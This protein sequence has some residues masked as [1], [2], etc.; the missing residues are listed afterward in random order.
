MDNPHEDITYAGVRDIWEGQEPFGFRPA[1]RRQHIYCV[2]KTGTGKST[3]LRNLILQDLYSGFG[4]GV[5]DPHGDLT[6]DVLDQFPTWRTDDLVHFD[7]G[8]RE[9]PLALNLLSSGRGIS[10]HLI[11]SAVVSAF[12]AIWSE[13][14]GA[15]LEY[16]LFACVSALC[17]CQSVSLLG[18]GRM[19]SDIT[20]RNWVV[21][22]VKDPLVKSFWEREFAGYDK[23]FL[24]EVISPVQNKVG[25]LMMSPPLRN[26]L[27][28]VTSKVD[29]RFMLDR[30]RVFIASLSKGKLGEDKANLL[31][32]LIMSQFHLAAMSRADLSEIHRKPFHLYVDEFSSFATDTLASM[33][34][35]ARKYGLALVLGHQHTAQLKPH[36]REAVLGNV[37]TIISF[38][39]GESDAGL[40]ER[41]FGGEY[42]ASRFS[43]LDNYHVLVKSMAGGQSRAPFSGTTLPPIQFT[44]G[45]RREKLIRR[46]REK[47]AGRRDVVEEKI[48]RWTERIQS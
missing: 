44:G 28:Q 18:V 1:D 47:Y 16:L 48:K 2:G 30:S 22:Q 6:N 13:S 24:S 17:E 46:S 26:V 33:L 19:L 43:G 7:P 38:R 25:Q 41:E 4:V 32:A 37:G 29:F 5:I 12:K 9:F 3:L 14:W 15:R 42:H 36:L 11:A 35:E 34:S 31:G 23:R 21:R 20:Y 27:G 45:R 40:L 10:P 39:V 8:D